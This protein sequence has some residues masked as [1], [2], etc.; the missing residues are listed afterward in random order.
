MPLLPSEP[1]IFPDDLLSNPAYLE[2]PSRW[3]VLHTR[4][5]AEKSLARKLL[6]LQTRF[7]L[8][9]HEHHWCSRGRRFQAH[10]PLFPGYLFLHDD[11]EALLAARQTNHV[12]N[13]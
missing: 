12:A 5:R 11:S 8:P 10:L 9:Q 7:F 4:P 6:A 3:W 2:G 13:C 1:F